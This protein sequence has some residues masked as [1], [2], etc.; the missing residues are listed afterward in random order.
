MVSIEWIGP[1]LRFMSA[2]SEKLSEG[3]KFPFLQIFCALC[4]F[5][6]LATL[7]IGDAFGSAKKSWLPYCYDG[8]RSIQKRTQNQISGGVVRN[9]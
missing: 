5:L 7:A 2:L 9:A 3:T 4:R 1:A 6:A 8:L